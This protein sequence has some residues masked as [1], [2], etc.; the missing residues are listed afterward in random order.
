MIDDYRILG[1]V[2]RPHINKDE[3]L[4]LWDTS[5][6]QTQWCLF[7]TPSDKIDVVYKLQRLMSSA[8]A[9]SGIGL[10]RVDPNQGIIGVVYQASHR[11][12]RP[13]GDYVVI[14]STADLCAYAST[15]S[16]DEQKIRWKKWRSSTK[17]VKIDLAITTTA[18]ISGSR[19]FTIFEGISYMPH[20]IL[21]RFY[22]FSP[23]VRGRRY[24]NRPPV[25]DHIVDAGCVAKHVGTIS[26][27]VSE[28]NLLMFNVGAKQP[29]PSVLA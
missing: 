1:I 2:K 29:D 10:H 24:P 5:G 4:V 27:D 23:G 22:D 20:E 26:W 6:S 7:E 8:S 16:A 28:D 11:N 17:V 21:L 18:C 12:A 3:L 15:R 9:R 25:R 19:L 14:I 13:D